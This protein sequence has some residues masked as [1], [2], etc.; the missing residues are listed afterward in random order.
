M[1]L[2]G[3]G[4]VFTPQYVMYDTPDLFENNEDKVGQDI[5]EFIGEHGFTGFHVPSIGMG[6]FDI[7]LCGKGYDQL[8]ND[9]PNPDIRTFEALEM[10]IVKTYQA[11]GAIHIWQWGDQQRKQTPNKWGA[12]GKVDQRLQRYIAARLGPLPGWS[13]GY[14]FDLFEWVNEKQLRMWHKYLQNHF[15]WKHFLG[16]RSYSN[17]L[18]QI[19]GELDYSSY[20]QHRPAYQKY[21]ETI[22]NITDKPSFSEDRFR[23][24]NVEI[25][26]SKDYDT[27][28]TRRGLWHSTMA[29]GVA[30]IWGCL[31]SESSPEI[32]HSSSLPY[33]N[34]NQI[35]TYSVYFNDHC[36]FL[37]DMKVVNEISDGCALKDIS[38]KH[39]IFYIEDSDS[40][41]VDLS[42][43]ASGQNAVAVDTK[44]RYKEINLGKLKTKKQKLYLPY[45]SDWAIAIGHFN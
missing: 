22:N 10:L 39:F 18:R 26:K 1:G 6:W 35:K 44:K 42:E 38:N 21:V 19:C 27:L 4:Q 34:K 11:G 13:M 8:D 23:I 32:N 14:G 24:R 37:P 9:D 2:G 16:A 15:G 28:L 36:R 12:N 31:I 20:E 7:K 40:I 45:E 29:G 33:P 43:M 17:Q 30:N 25:Y 3:T 5:R 41:Q